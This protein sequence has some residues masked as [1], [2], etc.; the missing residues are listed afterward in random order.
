MLSS[1]NFEFCPLDDMEGKKTPW[2][3]SSSLLKVVKFLLWTSFWKLII[4]LRIIALQLYEK[5]IAHTCKITVSV[6]I[7]PCW[8]VQSALLSQE[9][10]DSSV[11][12]LCQVWVVWGPAQE[13][14]CGTCL[15]RWSDMCLVHL[16]IKPC[17]CLK[18]TLV[19]LSSSLEP[20]G[21][22]KRMQHTGMCLCLSLKE[23]LE[24]SAA[25]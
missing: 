9:L 5:E 13:R 1:H 23:E 2:N 15:L 19:L 3:G 16:H 6:S 7:S 20:A 10:Q 24:V 8:V 25:R 4:L 14:P 12:A 21:V 17:C 22:R 11:S 18:N